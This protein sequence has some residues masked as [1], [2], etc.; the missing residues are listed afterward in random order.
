[1]INILSKILLVAVLLIVL[2]AVLFMVLVV[3]I[4]IKEL[5]DKIKWGYYDR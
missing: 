2:L 3:Y 4:A 5:K 1:M